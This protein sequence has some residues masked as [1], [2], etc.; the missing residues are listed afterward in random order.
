MKEVY[1]SNKQNGIAGSATIGKLAANSGVDVGD[2]TI[3]NAAGAAAVNIQD[4]GN[5]ITVGGTVAVSAVGGTVGVSGTVTASNTVGDVAHDAVDSGNPVK[6]GGKAY[7]QDGTAPGTAVAE[8]D[9][10]QFI[11]DVYGRQF[12][13]T[14]HPNFWS[15]SDNQS[16]A[17]TNTELKAT[18]GSGLS[19]YVT[20]IIISNGATAG[21]I[22]LVEDTGGTPVDVLE[23]MYFAINGGAVI[24][25]R[26]PIKITA[27]KNLGYT[28]VDCTS[29]S[30]TVCG[31]IAP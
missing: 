8:N 6:V 4:G 28:S 23:V 31:Y 20:D 7:N 25:L 27:N 22:K 1:I 11:T 2:V 18:P 5:T 19:L 14:A 12:V 29:H 15:A 21:N 16:S 24:S 13:E 9:R 17:Q 26:T 3:N 30:V 10:A